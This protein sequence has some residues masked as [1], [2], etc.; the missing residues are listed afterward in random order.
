MYRSLPETT[1]FPFPEVTS[2]AS[3]PVMTPDGRGSISTFV[4]ELILCL[5]HP[6]HNLVYCTRYN[7]SSLLTQG[8]KTL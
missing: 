1:D 7:V 6:Y 3:G 4:A 5:Q 2:L 8:Y